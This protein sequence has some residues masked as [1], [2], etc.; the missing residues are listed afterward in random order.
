MNVY[1]IA[2]TFGPKRFRGAHAVKITLLII[3][4]LFEQKGPMYDHVISDGAV[5]GRQ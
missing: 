1:Y 2:E 4:K 5:S 3:F